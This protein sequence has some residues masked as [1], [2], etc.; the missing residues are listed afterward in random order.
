MKTV[1]INSIK[2]NVSLE[3]NKFLNE[4]KDCKETF[5]FLFNLGLMTGEIIK[6]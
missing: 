5:K 4:N 3:I 2:Y 6:L 1:T